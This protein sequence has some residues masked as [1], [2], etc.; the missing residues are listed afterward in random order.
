MQNLPPRPSGFHRRDEFVSDSV[1]L[2]TASG[3][4]RLSIVG[5]LGY[6]ESP[7]RTPPA[8]SL[9][10]PPG[11][12]GIFQPIL[13]Q[14]A[15]ETSDLAVGQLL[16]AV[17]RGDADLLLPLQAALVHIISLGENVVVSIS[18]VC[19]GIVIDRKILLRFQAEQ[20][21]GMLEARL[22]AAE[23]VLATADRPLHDDEWDQARVVAQ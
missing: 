20:E 12:M 5:P 22:R 14:A 17:E 19:C 15:F 2:L 1:Q 9:S 6:D 7:P 11:P 4:A 10:D 16:T 8:P 3:T 18:I 23:Q 13:D 21:F